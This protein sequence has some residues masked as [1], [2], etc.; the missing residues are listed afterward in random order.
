MRP[1]SERV[2]LYNSQIKN[3]PYSAQL[4]LIVILTSRC[5]LGINML[6]HNLTQLFSFILHKIDERVLSV[7]CHYFVFCAGVFIVKKM[8]SYFSLSNSKICLFK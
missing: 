2:L 8:V 3:C 6:L 7:Q 4:E 1:G 5:A